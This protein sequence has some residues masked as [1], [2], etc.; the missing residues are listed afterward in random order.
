[1]NTT[2]C[3]NFA[4]TTDTVCDVNQVTYDDAIDALPEWKRMGYR[5]CLHYEWMG[6]YGFS[7][8]KT[9]KLQIFNTVSKD[10]AF[11]KEMDVA[12]SKGVNQ[13]QLVEGIEYFL[14]LKCIAELLANKFA[15]SFCGSQNLLE[16][17]WT[18]H[19]YV[20]AYIS[21]M[22]ERD[23]RFW[24]LR[25]T[26]VILYGEICIETSRRIDSLISAAERARD[27]SMQMAAAV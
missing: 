27:E 22:S 10:S 21:E 20:D 25:Q 24:E 7:W 26:Q 19:N 4:D 6:P 2:T 12:I 11:G 18:N 16:P 14:G 5:F 23:E 8:G 13:Q 17:G 9:S 1:M 15:E 3:S